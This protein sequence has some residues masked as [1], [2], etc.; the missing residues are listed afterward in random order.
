MS[1]LRRR[2]RDERLGSATT[3]RF[4]DPMYVHDH[5]GQRGVGSRAFL[6]ESGPVPLNH[7]V[8]DP[9]AD[10][11]EFAAPG[12]FADRRLEYVV[13]RLDLQALARAGV[14]QLAGQLPHP[15]GEGTLSELVWNKPALRGQFCV[16]AAGRGTFGR[17]CR[18]AART[19]AELYCEIG[20]T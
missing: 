20:C 3:W 11:G 2:P 7:Y 18:P 16:F 9:S 17:R 15:I 8:G 12:P 5:E 10:L 4:A 6:Y 13:R 19:L 14:L 1:G